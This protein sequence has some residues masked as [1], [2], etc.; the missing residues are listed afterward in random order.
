M[1]KGPPWE[2]RLFSLDSSDLEVTSGRSKCL[3]KA[4]GLVL[5]KGLHSQGL[6]AEFCLGL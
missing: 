4:A 3:R 1:V 6:L 2:D 5:G